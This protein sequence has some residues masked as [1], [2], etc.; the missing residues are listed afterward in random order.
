MGHFTITIKGLGAHHNKDNK[1][2]ADKMAFTFVH[3][4]KHAGHTLSEAS[5]LS[6]YQEDNLLQ[7]G[8]LL[9]YRNE[10][11]IMS[12]GK[13]TALTLKQVREIE[14]DESFEKSGESSWTNENFR[15]LLDTVKVLYAERQSKQ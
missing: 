1:A 7:I 3:N 10:Q 15:K 4:L 12:G 14:S 11:P 8:G 5:F 13:P 6:N 2:D 9:D